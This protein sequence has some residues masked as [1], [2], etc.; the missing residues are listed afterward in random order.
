MA[1]AVS[2]IVLYI[3]NC[4]IRDFHGY[5]CQLTIYPLLSTMF[6][7]LVWPWL[8][9]ATVTVIDATATP[10]VGALVVVTYGV[11]TPVTRKL[12]KADGTISFGGWIGKANPVPHHIT[13]SAAGYADVRTTVQL[14]GQT[15]V[16]FNVSL[17][18]DKV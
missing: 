1:A 9:E 13:V 10:V 15:T 4:S 7:E 14:I 11:A 16:S 18:P 17:G 2:P 5:L 6:K 8:G 12:T 3:Y